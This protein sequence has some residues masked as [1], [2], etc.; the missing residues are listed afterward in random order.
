[1][2]LMCGSG[3]IINTCWVPNCCCIAREQLAKGSYC[4]LPYFSRPKDW[5]HCFFILA[6]QKQQGS[7]PHRYSYYDGSCKQKP[8]IC[9]FYCSDIKQWNWISALTFICLWLGFHTGI[10]SLSLHFPPLFCFLLLLCS[11]QFITGGSR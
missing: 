4:S 2:S 10:V 6:V 11:G 9:C 7:V 3:I 5:K 8:C 1:M